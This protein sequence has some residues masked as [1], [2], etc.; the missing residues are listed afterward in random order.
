MKLTMLEAF[1]VMLIMALMLFAN[2]HADIDSAFK[3]QEKFNEFMVR[4]EETLSDI[5]SSSE[6]MS[7]Y[8]PIP[9]T[10]L[11]EFDQNAR[12][13]NFEQVIGDYLERNRGIPRS[14][15]RMRQI[16]SSSLFSG[17]SFSVNVEHSV[18]SIESIPNVISVYPVYSVSGPKYF[19]HYASSA[20]KSNERAASAIAHDLTG[21]AQVH[22]EIKNFGKGVRVAVIDTGID[23]LHPALGGCFGPTCKVAFGYDLVGDGYSSA[24]PNPVPDD[25]PLDNCSA[26]S[27]G[28]HVAGIVAANATAISQTGFTPIVPFVGVAP[29]AILGAYR[30]FGC[31]ADSTGTDMITAAI[32]LAFDQKADIITMSVGGPGSFAETSDAIAAQRVTDKGVYFTISQGNDGAQGLQTGGNPAISSGAMAVASVDNSNVPQL[33]FITPDGK[34]IFYSAGNS[35]GGWQSNV[36]SI[37]VV[38]DR[39]ATV[40]DGCS[41]PVKPVT[42]AVVLYS[43]NPADTCNSAVRCDKAADAGASGCLIYN[44]GAITGSSKIPSGSISLADGQR[45]LAITAQNAS[46]L[47]SFTNRLGFASIATAGTLSSFSAFGPTGDLLF[48]PQITGIGGFVYSTIS[49]YAAAQQKMSDAYA[50][51]SGTSMACPYLAGTLALFLAQIGNPGPETVGNNS[52]NTTR[53]PSFSEVRNL[54]QSNAKPVNI[55]GTQMLATIVRQGAGLVN[56]FQALTA[57]TIISPSELALNDT[58][59]QEKSYTIKVSN[60]GKKTAWYKIS[61]RG[62]ALAT[63]AQPESDQLLPTPVYSSDYADVFIWPSSFKLQ[64]GESF[65]VTLRFRAPLTAR[66][67]LLPIF[68]GFITVSNYVDGK[69]SHVPYAGVVGDYKNAKILVRRSPLGVGTGLYTANGLMISNG[70]NMNFTTS[71]GHLVI[72]TIAWTT[73]VIFIEVV[74]AEESTHYAADQSLGMV[75]GGP[76]TGPLYFYNV[77]KNGATLTGQGYRPYYGFAWTGYVVKIDP[78][79]ENTFNATRLLPGQ[80]KLRFSALKHFGDR[81]N[82]NDYDVHYTPMFHVVY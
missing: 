45:I 77:P 28:T 14:A 78:D 36:N 51:Y 17:A 81:N 30:I 12:I 34:E 75:Y 16:I 7:D 23:Y 1:F 2:V 40:N 57:N 5:D 58:L 66:P 71:T 43:Y 35:F 37:I 65:I 63:G 26:G 46:A 68:S 72:L 32:Y 41:D 15:I 3:I 20:I 21:V 55:Y 19:K 62:A 48:K 52:T 10:Y 13:R 42:G 67:E 79:Q 8:T 47:F 38:N 9:N 49:S 27:H 80:Y 70:Q 60:I 11:V 69:V 29:Q 64:P 53:R 31:N 4:N 74:S 6:T 59:R 56:V 73:R 76:G 25:D 39:Q 61:H 50:A 22:D 44:V 82:N 33:Y 24:N 18:K 54:F